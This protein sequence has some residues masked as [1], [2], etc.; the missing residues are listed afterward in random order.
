MVMP[1]QS[2]F[3]ADEAY[4]HVLDDQDPLSQFRDLFHIPLAPNGEP[5]I[6]LCGNSLGLMV[7]RARSDV[8]QV[9]DRWEELGIRGY[10]TGE[11]AWL[12]YP[13]LLSESLAQI[14]GGRP[15]E[16]IT[17]GSLTNNIHS[18]LAT[19]YQPRGQR[20]RVVALDTGFPSDRYALQSMLVLRGLRPEEIIL[21]VAPRQGEHLVREEAIE[22]ILDAHGDE[23][24]LV[25]LP[26]VHYATG[27]RFDIERFTRAAHARGCLVGFDLAHAVGNVP[28]QLHDWGVDFAVWC[29]Y[30]YLSAGAGA[31]AGCFVHENHVTNP[32][33]LH[34]AG[35]WGNDPADRFEMSDQFEPILTADRFQLS[36]PSVLSM[37]PLI[38]SLELFMQ[39]GL[40]S[41]WEKSR[42]LTAYLEVLLRE[43]AEQPFD[44][45][46][47]SDPDSR[48]NQLSI[49]LQGDAV[50]VADALLDN[51]V[52]I[53]ERPPN[54][55]RVAP[56]P[57]YNRYLEVWRFVQIFEA[58]I[59]G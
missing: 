2:S 14:V 20:R 42:R 16:V 9:L 21:P 55:I 58:V 7:K 6:Y 1:G 31:G 11:R 32:N 40:D 25:F 4:A 49:L 15:D 27:Q 37:T 45:I 22:E 36:C 10:F 33:L 35:W 34:P 13:G 39:A 19:F 3:R 24:A 12:N 44:I 50:Q 29:G 8:E 18:M 41:I 26:G 53:D 56:V 5:A 52:F 57:L 30:K 23:V 17:M 38:A 48:G 59:L 43:L 54:L 46:T 51:G 47:P 28:L